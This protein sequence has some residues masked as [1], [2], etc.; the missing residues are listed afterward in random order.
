MPGQGYVR[1]AQLDIVE[2]GDYPCK[3][4]YY[5]TIF[6]ADGPRTRRADLLQGVGAEL[7]DIRRIYEEEES[8]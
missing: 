3:T 4:S 8:K 1:R 6:E 7:W 2:A 5:E